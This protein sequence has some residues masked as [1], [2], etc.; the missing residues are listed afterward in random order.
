MHETRHMAE[1]W[2][3]V[4]KMCDL[5][6]AC[7]GSEFHVD[8]AIMTKVSAPGILHNVIRYGSCSE[9]KHTETMPFNQQF[10]PINDDP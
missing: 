3:F 5:L 6:T 1:L 10:K 9:N 8:I 7:V 2:L 4:A